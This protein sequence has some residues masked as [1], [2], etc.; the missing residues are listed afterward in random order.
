MSY[1][2]SEKTIFILGVPRSGTSWLAKIFDAHPSV[3]YRHEPDIIDRCETIP[4]ICD[5]DLVRKHK[6]E[7]AEWLNRLVSIRR[8]KCVATLPIFPKSFHSAWQS[9]ERRAMIGTLKFAQVVPPLRQTANSIAIPD[10][11]D[12][13]STAW[14]KLV[15]K[16]VSGM[17]RAGLFMAAAPESRIIVIVRH[18]C[19]QVESMLRGVHW[20]LFEDD[21]PINELA[22]TPQARRHNLTQ[23]SL[24][25][26]PFAAQLAWNWV[27]QNE[28]AMEALEGAKNVKI[29][30]F[31]DLA[32]QP[33]ETARGLF[34]FCGLDWRPEV[35]R[36][37]QESTRG[38]GRESYYQL[39]RDPIDAYTKWRKQ[40]SPEEIDTITG[41]AAQSEV[42]RMFLTDEA[43]LGFGT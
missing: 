6:S 5:A 24:S 16:S 19:G 36:F 28:M 31:V 39:K 26:E 29:V 27:I 33:E 34:Q 25:K 20:S 15:V 35:T 22:D 38:T 10:F 4:F 1:R 3:I 23:E 9:A 11:V 12:L 7:A 41:I 43:S 32:E 14:S 8:L 2:Y 17:G 18:P 37:V 30:R 40:L 21:I 13:D 42:G